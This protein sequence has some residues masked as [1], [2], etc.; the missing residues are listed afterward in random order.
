MATHR[1]FALLLASA[2]RP[3]RLLVLCLFGPHVR[4]RW[5]LVTLTL[6][7]VARTTCV[8]VTERVT[9]AA[10]GYT[11]AELDGCRWWVTCDV[12]DTLSVTGWHTMVLM[13]MIVNSLHIPF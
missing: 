2:Y 6:T 3:A 7:D 5:P 13:P 9:S 8:S 10:A 12:P 11:P 1:R 4:G